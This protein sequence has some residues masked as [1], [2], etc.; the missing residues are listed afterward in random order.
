[1]TQTM[2]NN[3]RAIP[4]EIKWNANV[5]VYAS[6]ASLRTESNEFG[7]IGGTDDEPRLRCVLPYTVLRK[8]G[9]RMIRFRTATIPL[10][11]QLSVDEEKSFLN[12]VVEYFRSSGADLILPSGNTAIFRTYPDTAQVAPYGTYILDLDRPEDVL[13]K[14]IQQTHRRNIRKAQDAGVEVKCSLDYLDMS[15]ELF[16]STLKRSGASFKSYSDFKRKLLGLGEHLKI[17]AAMHDGEPQSCLVSPFSRYSAYYCYGGSTIEQM[18]GSAHLLH[19]EAIKHFR[20]MGVRFFDFQGVR[21]NPEE[22]TKQDGIATFK[23]GFGGTLIEGYAWKCSL[24][25]LKSVVYSLGVRL[26]MGGDIVD[27]ERRRLATATHA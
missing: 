8:G 15:Y 19:W 3:L 7:W 22:G 1:M 13:W 12:N 27:Q 10:E 2:V 5:P 17:F 24:R 14:E 16:A 11:A 26:L 23:R 6:E 25:P 21:I 4:V 18:R 9:L 20:S